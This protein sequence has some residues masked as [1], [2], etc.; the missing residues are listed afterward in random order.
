MLPLN[1]LTFSIS[2]LTSA[3]VGKA[4]LFALE[5]EN[6]DPGAALANISAASASLCPVHCVAQEGW[7]CD[8]FQFHHG[9]CLLYPETEEQRCPL[10]AGDTAETTNQE[11]TTSR[12]EHFDIFRRKECPG[13]VIGL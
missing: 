5:V 10:A 7:Y 13:R 1:T 3:R 4:E 9:T 6:S 8:G 12:A 11:T 2:L